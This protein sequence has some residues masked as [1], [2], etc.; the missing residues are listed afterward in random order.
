M[1]ARRD[2]DHEEFVEEIWQQQLS[3]FD[4]GRLTPAEEFLAQYTELQSSQELLLDVVLNEYELI[5]RSGQA[6]DCQIDLLRRFPKIRAQLEKQFRLWDAFK[7]HEN[8]SVDIFSGLVQPTNTERSLD[9]RFSDRRT[10]GRGATAVVETAFDQTLQQKV[11]LKRLL[12]HLHKSDRAR[13]RFYREAHAVSRLHH[14]NIVPI[15]EIIEQE[16]EVVLVSRLVKGMSLRDLVNQ[17]PSFSLENVV[18]W[19]YQIAESLHYAHENGVIHRDIKPSNILID[20]DNKAMLIDFGLASVDDEMNADIT[21]TGD[22]IGTPAFMSPEQAIG[23]WKQIDA[24]TDVYS[25][26]ATLYW[27]LTGYPP[28]EGS[29]SNVVKSVIDSEPAPF[30][31]HLIHERH[32]LKTIID[33]CMRKSP[34]ERYHTS[35]ELADDLRR[36]QMGEMLSA[37][38][39]TRFNKIVKHIS[40]RPAFFAFMTITVLLSMF[41]LGS[42]LQL[43]QVRTQ[44]NRARDA[45]A[46]NQQLLMSASMDAGRLAMRQG[47]LD[48]A[49]RHFEMG[50]AQET[51][52]DAMVRLLLVECLFSIGQ[53]DKAAKWLEEAR[54][55]S[56]NAKEDALVNYWDYEFTI[57]GHPNYR[58]PSSKHWI[59]ELSPSKQLFLEGLNAETS[60]D[61]LNCFRDS[62]IDDPYHHSARKMYLVMALSMAQLDDAKNESRLAQQLYPQDIDF[63]LIEATAVAATEGFDSAEFIVNKIADLDQSEEDD[64]IRFL[65]FVSTISKPIAD[66]DF[67]DTQRLS[68]FSNT[69]DIFLDEHLQRFQ[70]RGW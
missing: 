3:S 43:N 48:Q 63:L 6:A 68:W 7:I 38:R 2:L 23:D 58:Y 40:R 29:I 30:T 59:S 67:F 53:F 9:S 55:L 24:R 22:L 65:K 16:D 34:N 21:A 41:L 51:D 50:V 54:Q 46:T 8:Q 56:L 12:K 32:D 14:P 11:A 37:K 19:T 61:A 39:S 49:I 64:W 4:Q 17:K 66:Q 57:I 60:E 62:F 35:R 47:N 69:L 52:H 5:I 42:L 15:F 45:E 44:R 33:K 28:F 13:Q 18:D 25:T 31:S 1:D 70:K 10:I 20:E 26:G 27:L 36:L